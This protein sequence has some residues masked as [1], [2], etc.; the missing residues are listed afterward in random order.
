MNI[1]IM[2]GGAG[3]R[4]S[5]PNK[6][7]IRVCG[8]PMIEHVI[9]SVNGL[10]RIYIATT[11]R[12]TEIINWSRGRGYEV[13]MTSGMGYPKD[14]LEALQTIGA[15]TLFMPSDMPFMTREFI[16]KFLAMTAYVASPMITLMVERG[17]EVDFTGVSLVKKLELTRGIIPWTSLVIPWTIELLNINTQKDLEL[18]H[19]LC[20]MHK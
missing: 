18:A 5:N 16:R 2:A 1:V 17:G 20:N 19:S 4:L 11:A 12:H 15:P 10:G 14:L 3:S 6:A 13:L 7:L 9:H 8:K